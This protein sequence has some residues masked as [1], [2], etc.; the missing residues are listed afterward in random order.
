MRYNEVLSRPVALKLL[1]AGR[2]ASDAQL[3]RFLREA[4]AASSLRHEH[5]VTV[6]DLGEDRGR[7]YLAMDRIEGRSLGEIVASEGPI[8]PRRAFEIGQ[9]IARALQHAHEH[10]I[11]HRDVKPDN[12]LIE[13]E[14]PAYLTDFGLARELGE[15][16][17]L[18]ATGQVVGT[19]AYAAPEQLA[20]HAV[21]ARADLYSLGATLF[22]AIAGKP[23]FDAT[24]YALLSWK[25]MYEPAPQ[26]RGARAE[27]A[28]DVDSVVQSASRRT[29]R[30]VTRARPTSRRTSSGS[31]AART[32]ARVRRRR[33]E[34]SRSSSSA[35]G[36]SRRARRRSSS[37]SRS[38]S[39]TRP[40]CAASSGARR[41]SRIAS[42]PSGAGS[43]RRSSATRPASR[44]RTSGGASSPRSWA[45]RTRA[46]GSASSR[47]RSPWT[48]ATGRA[49]AS[50]CGSCDGSRA[51]SRG[52]ATSPARARPLSPRRPSSRSAL[53]GSPSAPRAPLLLLEAEIAR[54]ELRDPAL[55]AK[56]HASLAAVENEGGAPVYARA[57][58]ELARGD[59]A[60]AASSCAAALAVAPDLIVARFLDADLALRRND[61]AAALGAL[62]RAL[63]LPDAIDDAEA[64]VLR[65]RS[66]ALMGAAPRALEDLDRALE[67]DPV[68]P[69]ARR[70]RGRLRLMAGQAGPAAADLERALH[71]APH[72]PEARL[73]RARARALLGQREA[74][75]EDLR[76]LEKEAG[77]ARLPR[78]QR[79]R[80]H[81]EKSDR[82]SKRS[83][84][85]HAPRASGT[86]EVDHACKSVGVVRRRGH[87]GASH[88]RPGPEADKPLVTGTEDTKIQCETRSSRRTTSRTSRSRATSTRADG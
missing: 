11:V 63:A 72:D 79:D 64:F 47:E 25:V 40:S 17:R 33:F 30:A 50:A 74:A 38:P 34:G 27:V 84:T 9:Q 35:T 22:D 45:S 26:L 66:L 10:G 53:S 76:D 82:L 39:A 75:L 70:E 51:S 24:T 42:S 65:A 13:C 87:P 19:P 88:R 52:R 41:S 6:H 77:R 68:D 78:H 81:A 3:R 60:A 2:D 57:R 71:R 4:R 46:P 73:L 21:D 80:R 29:R 43:R 31:C 62:D 54:R 1:I 86:R 36:R 18:T 58:L 20:G 12:I 85:R 67:L 7:L 49:A 56:A 61:A 83:A 44:S 23:P 55:A 32:C 8:A 59:T 15:D 14:R 5:I 37:G 69:D 48:P 16:A 28:R